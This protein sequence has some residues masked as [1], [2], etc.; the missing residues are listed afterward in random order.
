VPCGTPFEHLYT[1]GEAVSFACLSSRLT[2]ARE[3][4]WVLAISLK[5]CPRVRS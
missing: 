2:V 5:L 1:D 4:R 3:M